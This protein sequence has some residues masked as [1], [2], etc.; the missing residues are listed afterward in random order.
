MRLC[1]VLWDR[2]YSWSASGFWG[3]CFVGCGFISVFNCVLG[4]TTKRYHGQTWWFGILG[5]Y[6]LPLNSCCVWVPTL[7]NMFKNRYFKRRD[8]AFFEKFRVQ[9]NKTTK[10]TKEAI[11]SYV[12]SKCKFVERPKDFWNCILELHQNIISKE[13]DMVITDTEEKDLTAQDTMYIYMIL[14][15][16]KQQRI[17]SPWTGYVI[18]SWLQITS[19]L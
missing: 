3:C 7:R 5:T 12:L 13:G 2:K 9:R 11:K 17:S 10:M 1:E 8:K 15:P 4:H 19:L 16:V 18:L 14:V 6:A